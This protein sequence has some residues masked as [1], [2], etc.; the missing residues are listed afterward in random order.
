MELLKIAVEQGASDVHLVA[1]L[2][3]A[4]RVAGEIILWGG[5]K[6]G[7]EDAWELVSSLLNAE[8]KEIFQRDLQLGF[9]FFEPGLAHFRVS[10]YY[11]QGRVEAAIRVRN[12]AIQPLEELGL[13]ETVQEL[14]R[15]P[16]GLVLITG[17]TGTGKTTTLYAMMDLINHERRCKIIT[18]EDPIEYVHT[19]FKSIIV[20]Q[21]LG[22]DFKSFSQ[23]L[24]HILR[25]D[26]DV[27]C[28]GEMRD[29][30]T[31][32]AAVTAAETGHLVIATLH[33]QDAS[34]T[35]DR[36]IDA[37]PPGRQQQMRAQ[38]SN[39]LQGVISQ[40]LLP[41]V[42]RKS[43]VLACEVMVACDAVRN[44]IREGKTSG[45]YNAIQSGRALGMQTL[46]NSLKDL[47]GRGQV[48]VDVAAGKARNPR[49]ILEK[50]LV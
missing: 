24:T 5:E 14:T 28:V 36:I 38:L 34:Q 37:M 46:D 35:V 40:V 31:I 12:L 39:C 42:D 2:P 26:P 45:L 1:G 3:P 32:S 18:L 8:Q 6:L 20:Q 44:T 25:L 29:L 49:F 41:T 33:T 23:A 4:L 9:S 30:E 27:I 22:R 43:R 15:K 16:N 48:T 50:E 13:P 19:P 21:E 47:Y 10:L 17:P 11:S 7:P